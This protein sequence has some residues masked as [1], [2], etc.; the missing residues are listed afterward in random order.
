[1]KE[2]LQQASHDGLSDTEK[3]EKIKNILKKMDEILDCQKRGDNSRFEGRRSDFCNKYASCY[4]TKFNDL[5]FSF[6]LS[7]D[8]ILNKTM[9]EIVNYDG[10]VHPED[11]EDFI[12]KKMGRGIIGCTGTAKLFCALAEKEGLNCQVVMTADRNNWKKVRDQAQ[13]GTIPENRDIINGHQIVAVEFSN[14]LRA[15]DPG[16]KE[17]K[18]VYGPGYI[19]KRDTKFVDLG[20]AEVGK[21]IDMPRFKNHFVT[22]IIPPKEYEKVSSY[23]DVAN[24]Y[25][26]GNMN[27]SSFTVRL[28]QPDKTD[29]KNGYI[30]SGKSR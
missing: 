24:L 20:K 27:D 12:D 10:S 15:F 5:D 19:E 13:Y 17:E 11:T 23:Q 7:A 1:M 26:S 21:F 9:K 6:S 18:V 8:D 25:S 16:Y 30:F 2:R 14:G 29:P 3:M 4:N 22:A 28:K